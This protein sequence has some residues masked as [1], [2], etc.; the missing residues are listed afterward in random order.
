MSEKIIY[1][2]SSLVNDHFKIWINFLHMGDFIDHV[3][4]FIDRFKG[5]LLAGS[6]AVWRDRKYLCIFEYFSLSRYL[7]AL[8]KRPS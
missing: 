2:M 1:V 3:G 6:I 5:V 8:N 7:I 4:N